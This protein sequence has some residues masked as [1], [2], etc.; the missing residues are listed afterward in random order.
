M[1]SVLRGAILVAIVALIALT[2][3]L[4]SR[5]QGDQRCFG[6]AAADCELWHSGNDSA[7][8]AKYSSF[9]MDYNIT[10]TLAGTGTNDVD[11]KVT[12]TGPFSVDES[13]IS[14]ASSDPTAALTALTMANTLTAS[15]NA[16]GQS[17]MGTFEFRIV[18]GNLYFKG[19]QA[20]QNKWMFIS[21]GKALSSAMS[22]PA[23]T[24]ALSGAMGGGTGTGS[25]SNPATAIMN[26]PEVMAAIAKIPDIPGFIK[27]ERQ[28]D[29]SIGDEKVA[30]F[31]MN[32]DIL[33]L[34]KSK[35]FAPVLKA[36][37][38]SSNQGAE[39]DDKQVQQIVAIAQTVLKDTKFS[40]T[41]WVGT[42]D[43]LSHGLGIDFTMKV[44]ENTA[45]LMNSS[46]SGAAKPVDI[47]FHFDVKLTKIGQPVT[48]EAVTDAT[49]ID[50][51]SMMGGGSSS[52]AGAAP[53][54]SAK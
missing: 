42:T 20:T 25:S 5:A 36:G 28:A 40:I 46:S 10:F 2:P 43:K 32:F 15:L 54:S 51:S 27:V 12:G 47:N 17:Q 4:T 1:K 7:N 38:K 13:K 44:D 34:I 37:L 52:G 6:L 24:D 16:S 48:V 11:F 41:Q 9:V 39:V 29:L 30:Q 19:D 53:T 8:A 45:A 33:T 3:A 18:G 14:G 22:N 26:D 31:V 50:T 23:I 21:L 35:E 49:E